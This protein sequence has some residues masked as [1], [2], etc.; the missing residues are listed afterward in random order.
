MKPDDRILQLDVQGSFDFYTAVVSIDAVELEEFLRLPALMG[1]VAMRRHLTLD[2]YNLAERVL[3]LIAHEITHFIDATSTCWGLHHLRFLDEAYRAMKGGDEV[4]YHHLKTLHDHTRSLRLPPYYTLIGANEALGPPWRY[5][6]TIGRRFSLAGLIEHGRPITFC[7]FS[8]VDGTLLSRSPLSPVS[9]LETSAMAQELQVRF[10]LL[11]EVAGPERAVEEVIQKDKALKYLYDH[12]ITE[13]SVCAHLVANY[14]QCTDVLRA[15]RLAGVLSRL[16]LNFPAR[17]FVHLANQ[18]DL[19]ILFGV[20]RGHPYLQ[21]VK[22]G[23]GAGDLGMLYYVLSLA[24]PAHSFDNDEAVEAGVNSAVATLGLRVE[25][26]SEWSS[27]EAQSLGAYLATSPSKV[28]R[29]LS[30]AGVHNHQVLAWFTP[31]LEFHQLHLPKLQFG[32]LR[33]HQVYGGEHNM[34]AELEPDTCFDELFPLQ[35]FVV[36]FADACLGNQ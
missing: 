29:Q 9:I 26:L 4:L 18:S 3:P 36:N 1:Q 5:E 19:S 32:D 35:Q 16:T 11:S 15:Y 7:R 24:L 6:V 33:T 13:Y 25:Q 12:S 23:L 10:G 27:E 30:A 8:G 17:A 31:N 34:L 2:Q 14:Q 28:I 21:A 22:D 20:A